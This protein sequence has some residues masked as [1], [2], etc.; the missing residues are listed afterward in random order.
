MNWWLSSSVL[1]TALVV[2]CNGRRFWKK[3]KLLDAPIENFLEGACKLKEV[4]FGKTL[5]DSSKNSKQDIKNL[6]S[7]INPKGT[8]PPDKVALFGEV[9][10]SFASKIFS[11]ANLANGVAPSIGLLSWFFGAWKTYGDHKEK[12]KFMKDLH[13]S[14]KSIKEEI[15][16]K[17]DDLKDYIDQSNLFFE[18]SML[19][20]EFDQMFS[21]VS[22]CVSISARKERSECF[23]DRCS[24][25]K[26][27]FNKFAI[28]NNVLG[29]RKQTLTQEEE[30]SIK[31]KYGKDEFEEE[32]FKYLSKLKIKFY[33]NM[34]KSLSPLQI[35]RIQA[36]V[37]LFV[38]YVEGILIPCQAVNY[39]DK[40]ASK[41]RSF[42]F[43]QDEEE[44]KLLNGELDDLKN[45]NSEWS[46][47]EQ[48]ITYIDN[49]RFVIKKASSA[50]INDYRI[51]LSDF[52][53]WG[54]KDF[55]PSRIIKT[56]IKQEIINGNTM[57][58]V[59]CRM[60]MSTLNSDTC[61]YAIDLQQEDWKPYFD[62]NDKNVDRT[63][64]WVCYMN[65]RVKD[66]QYRN[67]LKDDSNE[68]IWK[69]SK[70]RISQKLN[71]IF[72]LFKEKSSNREPYSNPRNETWGAESGILRNSINKNFH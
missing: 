41:D 20:G 5:F 1:L 54:I 7:E 21:Y 66:K 67:N 58:K 42:K 35:R 40:L 32:K 30:R 60:K 38:G 33:N 68:Q 17:F 71:E 18:E 36:N 56:G 29:Q 37:I 47:K 13:Q 15:D 11:I 48:I 34:Y 19:R 65:L 62:A 51:L 64:E 63:L 2:N 24:F 61:D 26:S 4:K 10:G 49:A 69:L 44:L 31:E 25:V 28:Y 39:L 6:I 57:T 22:H 50:L 72:E 3:E 55:T 52:K 43:D 23:N 14:L 46:I 27:G 8:N 70:T 12:K 45:R 16:T 59:L 53:T 9:A